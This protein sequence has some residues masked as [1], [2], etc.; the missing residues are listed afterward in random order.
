VIA[1]CR[2]ENDFTTMLSKSREKLQLLLKHSTRCPTSRNAMAE[3]RRLATT[4]GD[5]DLSVVL[6]FETRPL[7]TWIAEQ[8]GVSHE[9]PQVIL[10][11][12]GEAVWNASHQ[13]I[14]LDSMKAAIAEASE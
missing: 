7:S 10:L 13:E 3:F 1:D 12:D 9:S 11:R 14:D 2:N 4:N 6:V 8:I 5:A